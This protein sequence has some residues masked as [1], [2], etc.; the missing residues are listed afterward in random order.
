MAEDS[1][2]VQ[3]TISG[4]LGEIVW[5]MSQSEVHKKLFI[6]ELEWY[7]M[8]P[9]MLSQF[10]V[11][12]KDKRPVGVVIWATVDKDVEERLKTGN[13]RLRGK[14]WNSGDRIWIVDV[15]SPFGDPSYLVNDLSKNI[16]QGK[17][18]YYLETDH[19]SGVQ[20]VVTVNALSKRENNQDKNP[21]EFN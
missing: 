3:Q 17:E 9:I 18:Y 7:I 14:E 2:A 4:V 15:I 21:T 16:F 19:K 6:G 5:L 11:Y 20:K 1:K 8:E 13:T 12:R 10:R